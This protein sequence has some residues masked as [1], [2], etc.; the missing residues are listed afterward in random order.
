[1]NIVFKSKDGFCPSFIHKDTDYY[2]YEDYVGGE[3]QWCLMCKPIKPFSTTFK[4]ELEVRNW[5]FKDDMQKEEFDRLNESIG[6]RWWYRNYIKNNCDWHDSVWL[7]VNE[8]DWNF[9]FKELTLTEIHIGQ[10]LTGYGTYQEI[11]ELAK[12]IIQQK[13]DEETLTLF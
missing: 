13:I 9:N 1:M 5:L 12:Q 7:I 6:N 8:K 2:L 11:L 3:Y 10:K 4:S